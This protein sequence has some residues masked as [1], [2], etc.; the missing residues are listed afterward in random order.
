MVGYGLI[1]CII[2]G[3]IISAVSGGNISIVVG[4]V[5]VAFISWAVAVFGMAIFHAYER[6]ALRSKHFDFPPYFLAFI[7]YPKILS[8]HRWAWIPQL[9]VLFVLVGSAG[10]RF[11]STLS[12]SGSASTIAANPLSFFSLSL[13][14]PVS[15]AAAASD[16]FVYYPETTPKWKP[17]LMTLLGLTLSFSMVNILGI[18]LASGIG[19]DMQWNTAYNISTG[20]LIV[21]GYNGL[22]GFGKFCSVIVALGVIA[23][24]IPGTYSAALSFQMLGRFPKS[25]PR[26]WW[27]CFVVACYFVCAI[28]GRDH[29][30]QIFQNF[31]A[32]MGYWITIFV[33]IVL[34]E[35]IF[36]WNIGFDWTAWEDQNRLP[37]GYAALTAFLVG[38]VGCILS[39]YQV[40]YTGPIAKMVGDSGGDLGIWVGCSFALVTYPP[41]RLVEMMV[42]GR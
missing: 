10:P 31:L 12:S 14:V 7:F 29:L 37:I 6:C 3:Q 4:I 21:A 15:W 26:Y 16:F 42:L 17:F 22:A 23:N 41:L 40:Y 9:V 28:A 8:N 24:N 35:H 13:S 33:T 30:F 18:G 34:E 20:A 39:M 27:A 38:W 2:G 5:I 1:D 32:L 11:D 19:N 25:I 36:R